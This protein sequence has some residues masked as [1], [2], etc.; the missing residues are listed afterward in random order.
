[1]DAAS[2]L[3]TVASEPQKPRWPIRDEKT[4]LIWLGCCVRFVQLNAKLRIGFGAFAPQYEGKAG[5]V[6][7]FQK[8]T[9]WSTVNMICK[10]IAAR[11]K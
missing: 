7:E 2:D 3:E 6:M 8:D 1:M 9:P 11:V 5:W 10:F 4:G